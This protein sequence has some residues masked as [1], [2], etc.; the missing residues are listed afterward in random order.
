VADFAP[1]Q[2]GGSRPKLRDP[3]LGRSRVTNGALLAGDNRSAW[4]RR[5]KD[6]IALHTSDLGGPDNISAAE[7]S[8]IRRCATLTVELERMEAAFAVAGEATPD[9][10]D[11]YQ[12]TAGN[13]RRLLESIG[14]SRRAKPVPTLSEYLASQQQEVIEPAPP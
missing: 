9:A 13:L 8:L 1:V 14:L 4:A 11:L 10:L 5:C 2:P 7:A 12:R 6:V 3:R